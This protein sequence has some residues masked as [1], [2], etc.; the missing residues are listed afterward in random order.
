VLEKSVNRLG[1]IAIMPCYRELYCVLFD[2]DHAITTAP[3]SI[4]QTPPSM[5]WW[6][7]V[8]VVGG[9][10][11]WNVWNQLPTCAHTEHQHQH[12]Q[13]C[14]PQC[15]ILFRDPIERVISQYYERVYHSQYFKFSN[16]TIASLSLLEWEELL[17]TF[18]WA[19]PFKGS[20]PARRR[21]TTNDPQ[22][23]QESNQES[24]QEEEESSMIVIDEGFSEITCR[25]LLQRKEST[26]LVYD[27]HQSM[28]LN[29]FIANSSEIQLAIDRMEQCVVGILEDWK[30]TVS[31]IDYW[32]P[33]IDFPQK[34]SGFYNIGNKLETKSNLPLSHINA[35]METNPCDMQLYEAVK[36][37]FNDQV[38]WMMLQTPHSSEQMK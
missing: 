17:L 13:P 8:S 18:R 32:F 33:W 25:M 4:Y 19:V 30:S 9:H 26:G 12:Q 6:N 21:G 10:F 29:I 5:P 2:I 1:L 37:R 34:S 7:N 15:L 35:I 38:Q 16:R 22:Q 31:V 24:N 27:P 28:F 3:V 20:K 36:K 11:E 14:Q 23:Q